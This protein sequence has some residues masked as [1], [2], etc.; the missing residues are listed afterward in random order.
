MGI[1]VRVQRVVGQEHDFGSVA[2]REP[3]PVED[4][5]HVR[6]LLGQAIHAGDGSAPSAYRRLEP[7]RLRRAIGGQ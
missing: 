7:N 4:G 1:G 3:G 6:P 2:W 5:V